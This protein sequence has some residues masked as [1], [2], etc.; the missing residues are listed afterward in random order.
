MNKIR[1]IKDAG[2]EIIQDVYHPIS[3]QRV[4]FISGE[5]A[6]T[7][8]ITYP[9]VRIFSPIIGVYVKAGTVTV[10][11]SLSDM[12]I[13]AVTEK[14]LAVEETAPYLA[15]FGHGLGTGGSGEVFVTQMG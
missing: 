5:S 14:H 2:G 13:P 7:T 9:V 11:A 3:S 6:R 1:S 12:F 10:E 8:E 15:F 4:H